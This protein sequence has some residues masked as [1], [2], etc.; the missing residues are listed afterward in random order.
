MIKP[1]LDQLV[2]EALIGEASTVR[3][4]AGYVT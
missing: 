4:Q 3:I 1:G 2:H